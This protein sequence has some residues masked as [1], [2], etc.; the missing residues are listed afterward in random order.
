MGPVSQIS[1]MF[2]SSLWDVKE[3]THYSR[4]VGDDVPGV[5]AVLCEDALSSRSGGPPKQKQPLP[6]ARDM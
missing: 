5:V 1:S 4:R 2:I 6:R 3:P